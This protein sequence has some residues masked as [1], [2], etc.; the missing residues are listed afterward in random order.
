[1]TRYLIVLSLLTAAVIAVRAIFKKRL[2]ARLVY[3]L[4]L[5]V[6]IK[7]CLPFSVF[8][9][10]LDL[11]EG[12]SFLSSEQGNEQAS[13]PDINMPDT[14]NTDTPD[15][16]LPNQGGTLVDPNGP[17]EPQ[18]PEINTDPDVGGKVPSVPEGSDNPAEPNTPE[19]PTPSLPQIPQEPQAPSTPQ[20]PPQSEIVNKPAPQI[21]SEKLSTGAI[22]GIVWGVGAVALAG[23]FAITAFTYFSKVKKGRTLVKAIGNHSIY[24][25]QNADTPCLIGKDIYL[26][27]SANTD[28]RRDLAI[29]HELTHFRGFMREDE[30][31]FLSYLA[32]MG[33]E[34]ADFRYSGSLMAFEYAFD[35]LYD[36][37]RELAA[38]I[39]QQCGSGMIRDIRAEDDYW[40]PYRN[41]AVSEMSGEIYE[42]YLQSNNQQSGLKSYGEMIDLLLAYYREG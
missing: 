13:K 4:W 18:N 39:A 17:T 29:Q 37:D 27:P 30:A 41:T 6:L 24:L 8:E 21:K 11:P 1:M 12:M 19:F 34:R 22:I 20:T 26:T 25:S 32:C 15:V 40:R 23:W 42:G 35:A 2:S 7:M 38:E 16:T 3:A 31:N 33:S 14:P 28:V 9:L 10:E 36:E 5:V